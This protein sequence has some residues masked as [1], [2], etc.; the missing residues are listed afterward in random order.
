MRERERERGKKTSMPTLSRYD[1]IQVVA[2]KQPKKEKD[3]TKEYKKSTKGANKHILKGS[4]KDVKHGKDA[5]S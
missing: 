4:I 5:R 2:S 3:E 1:L